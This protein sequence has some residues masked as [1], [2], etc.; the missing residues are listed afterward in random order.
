MKAGMLVAKL[1]EKLLGSN[2]QNATVQTLLAYGLP[3]AEQI[4]AKVV[5]QG[6]TKAISFIAKKIG[7]KV[8]L[9]GPIGQ[10]IGN[11]SSWL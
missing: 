5:N 11:A 8:A 2:S 10:I 4:V 6:A 7:L 1:V 9:D 3:Y